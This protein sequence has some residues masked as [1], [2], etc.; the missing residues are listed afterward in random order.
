MHPRSDEPADDDPQNSIELG[1][2]R[3]LIDVSRLR[4]EMRQERV[5]EPRTK[6]TAKAPPANRVIKK[7]SHRAA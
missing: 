6:K 1:L 4:D 5:V 7:S 3:L 2:L